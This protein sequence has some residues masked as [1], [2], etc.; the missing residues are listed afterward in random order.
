MSVIASHYTLDCYIYWCQCASVL[1]FLAEHSV[2]CRRNMVTWEM[3]IFKS[4][5]VC[6]CVCTRMYM[7]LLMCTLKCICH[8]RCM[9]YMSHVWD[10]AIIPLFNIVNSSVTFPNSITEIQK[11]VKRCTSNRENFPL[12]T[13]EISWSRG[14]TA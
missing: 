5:C 13:E 9:L 2:C 6:V 7:F 1:S 11:K 3:Q 12:V 4:G 8:C 10:K 14:A